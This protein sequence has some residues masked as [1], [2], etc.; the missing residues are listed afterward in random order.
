[1][2]TSDVSHAT[3]RS[4]CQSATARADVSFFRS[5]AAG[6]V[7]HGFPRHRWWLSAIAIIEDCAGAAA[8]TV[9]GAKEVRAAIPTQTATVAASNA[10]AT[11]FKC[12][13]A[14]A[15]HT[16]EFMTMLPNHRD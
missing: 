8:D 3:V 15:L 10:V 11:I 16:D 14:S 6:T 9:V 7:C 12:V 1:M 2:T 4:S 13:A 5:A